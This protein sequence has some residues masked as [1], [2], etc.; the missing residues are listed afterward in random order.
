MTIE[1]PTPVHYYM[2]ADKL[3][4]LCIEIKGVLAHREDQVDPPWDAARVCAEVLMSIGPQIKASEDAVTL[5]AEEML[6]PGVRPSQEDVLRA[7]GRLHKPV[8]ELLRIHFTLWRQPFPPKLREGQALVSALIEKPLT[9]ILDTLTK[10]RRILNDPEK[11]IHENSGSDFFHLK[12]NFSADREVMTLMG[13][14]RM[15]GLTPA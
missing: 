5:L 4:A 12:M 3:N 9:V 7:V 2:L 1:A 15:N 13:W 8:L 6:T 14:L 11:A 10:I